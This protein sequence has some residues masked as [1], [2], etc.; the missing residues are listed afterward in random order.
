MAPTGGGLYM[1][2]NRLFTSRAR[3]LMTSDALATRRR[4]I[5]FRAWH[6]G[7]REMDLILGRFADA[8][9]PTLDPAGLDRLEA[10]MEEADPDLYAWISGK[11]VP[12]D[13]VDGSLLAEVRAFHQ[14]ARIA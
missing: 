13:A 7:T 1:S 11:A 14:T 9:V 10:L 8:R 3:R 5:A 6:R 4:R 2:P 12:P